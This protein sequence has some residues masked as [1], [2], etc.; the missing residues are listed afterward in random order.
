M[1]IPDVNAPGQQLFQDIS[2]GT[3]VDTRYYTGDGWVVRSFNG[4]GLATVDSCIRANEA[5]NLGIN[6][7]GYAYGAAYGVGSYHPLRAYLEIHYSTTASYCDIV[8]VEAA[9]DSF[10]LVVGD[11]VVVVGRFTNTGNRTAYTLPLIA[12]CTG[13]TSDTVIVASLA[14]DD[15]VSVRTALPP[16]LAPGI[17]SL[18]LCSNAQGDWCRHN[19][20]A[21]RS[22]HMFPRGTR[23]AEDFE[24]EHSPSFPPAGWVV[25]NGG[26]TNTWHRAGPGDRY[27]HTGDFYATSYV[28]DDWLISYGLSPNFTTADTV[29]AF[30]LRPNTGCPVQVWALGSQNPNNV[31]G[32]LVDTVIQALGWHDLRIGLDQ[33]D[34]ETLYVGFRTS[35][36]WLCLDDVWFTSER[37]L[38]VEEPT[39]GPASGL[40]LSLG[41]NPVTGNSVVIR[42]QT[43]KAGP[44]LVE[45]IDASGRVA[46]RQ[47][48]EMALGSGQ[49]AFLA[50]GWPSGAY[51]VRV[52]AG[53]ASATAKCVVYRRRS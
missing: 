29:G 20:T 5:I 48:L 19:D 45:V 9:F 3:V 13:T 38:A 22:T 11:S 31:L 34:G 21:I 24:L 52:K 25:S 7:G 10:P 28:D 44:L 43:P 4:A 1:L 8:A 30:V 2:N 14:P 18:V 51:F 32:L 15:T 27:A 53:A 46:A 39:Q 40:R 37:V 42:Y 17:A 41:Q 33:F 6:G 35:G 36:G 26:D 12:S 50:G 49:F 16:A 47:R 23:S